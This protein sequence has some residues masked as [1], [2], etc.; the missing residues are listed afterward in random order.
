MKSTGIRRVGLRP[1][2]ALSSRDADVPDLE[3]SYRLFDDSPLFCFEHAK[4][5]E[6]PHSLRLPKICNFSKGERER[7][8][9]TRKVGLKKVKTLSSF[10]RIRG[11]VRWSGVRTLELAQNDVGPVGAAS[12]ANLLQRTPLTSLDLVSKKKIIKTQRFNFFFWCISEASKK[13]RFFT[14]KKK[15]VKALCERITY[16]R[17]ITDSATAAWRFSRERSATRRDN[18]AKAKEGKRHRVCWGF[19]PVCVCVCVCARASC[20]C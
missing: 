2:V 3:A 12:I 11:R 1:G 4:D 9:R 6:E 5:S 13:A 18:A 15:K 7:E 16:N 8:T 20:V 17:P 19:P 14:Q 10:C